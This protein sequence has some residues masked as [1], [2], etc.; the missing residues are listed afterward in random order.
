MTQEKMKR[1]VI[2]SVSAATLLTVCLIAVV[3]YQLVSIAVTKKRI[4][5]AKAENARLE[6]II[7]QEQGDLEY[8]LAQVGKE[9]LARKDGYYPGK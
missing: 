4:A 2:A 6:Q 7:E 1:T 8:Y 3:V 9:N 5:A